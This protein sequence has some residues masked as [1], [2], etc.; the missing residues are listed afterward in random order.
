MNLVFCQFCKKNKISQGKPECKKCEKQKAIAIDENFKLCPICKSSHLYCEK[1]FNRTLGCLFMTIGAV[2]VPWTYGISLLVLSLFDYVLYKRV[3]D[4][5][6]CY[7]CKSE[8]RNII[9]LRP[10]LKPFDHH[11]AELYE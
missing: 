4:I 3:K 8:F 10:S 11:I 7:K 1:S 9:K 6:S 2:L 5:V